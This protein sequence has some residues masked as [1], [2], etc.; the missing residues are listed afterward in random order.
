MAA[1]YIAAQNINWFIVIVLSV[2]Y[3]A[4]SIMV[5]QMAITNM[6]VLEAYN[7]EPAELASTSRLSHPSEVW[8]ENAA[9]PGVIPI[10]VA[11]LGTFMAALAYLPYNFL[12]S[13]NNDP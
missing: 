3:S 8:L 7:V 13:R 4:L 12:K 9:N 10:V 1:G 5:A 2:L 6:E 11:T